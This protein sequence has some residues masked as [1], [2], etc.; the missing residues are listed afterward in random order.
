MA[1]LL[2]WAACITSY[3]VEWSAFTKGPVRP[4]TMPPGAPATGPAV[5]PVERDETH[6]MFGRGRF[7]IYSNTVYTSSFELPNSDLN[8]HA[9][10]WATADNLFPGLWQW[11]RWAPGPLIGVKLWV[12][13]SICSLPLAVVALRLRRRVPEGHCRKCR[14]DLRGLSGEVCPECGHAQRA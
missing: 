7:A 11:Q 14:Y 8:S 2:V 6:Y 13:A 12:V 9:L 10:A 1:V 5:L 3:F 4:R